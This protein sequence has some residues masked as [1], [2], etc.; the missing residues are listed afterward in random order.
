MFVYF[1][2]KKC[3]AYFTRKPIKDAMYLHKMYSPL[4]NRQCERAHHFNNWVFCILISVL[5][6]RR[7]DAAQL[8]SLLYGNGQTL[9][10]FA[11][12]SLLSLSRT[13][14]GRRRPATCLT[15]ST[16]HHIHAYVISY[17]DTIPRIPPTAVAA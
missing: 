8:A 10:E 2:K 11:K 3:Y 17:T 7:G 14:L 13:L 4:Y 12:S 5:L 9:P 6:A 15:Y 16:G 1:L